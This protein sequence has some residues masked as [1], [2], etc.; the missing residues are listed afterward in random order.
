LIT[1]AVHTRYAN[2]IPRAIELLKEGL[3]LI[4]PAV[5]PKL[6]ANAVHNLAWLMVDCGRYREAR[7]ILWQQLPVQSEPGGHLDRLKAHWLEGRL[8]AA[9]GE[10]PQAEKDLQAAREGLE[11]AGLPCSAAIAGLDQA[12]VELRRDHVDRAKALALRS[13]RAFLSLEISR[14]AQAA[15]LFYEEAAKRR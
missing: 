3:S 7:R 1:K 10:L 11:A 5:D 4:D 15:I 6:A 13:A 12:G 14:E 8:N 9:L 2:D